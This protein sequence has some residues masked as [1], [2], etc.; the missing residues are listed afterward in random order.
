MNTF[1]KIK[2]EASGYP[3][4]CVT[5]ADKTDYVERVRQYEGISLDADSI[6]FNAGRR[7]VAKL[8]LNRRAANSRRLSVR[9]VQKMQRVSDAS[10]EH[11]RCDCSVRYHSR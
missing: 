4:E 2:M 1:M 7:A 10:I 5:A 9:L 6:E 3:P 11:E 8:C